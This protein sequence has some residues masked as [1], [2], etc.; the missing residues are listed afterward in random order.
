MSFPI[1]QPPTIP[2]IGNV[3]LIEPEAPNRSFD[4]LAKKYGEIYQLDLLGEKLI[5]VSSYKL[6]NELSDDTRFEKRITNALME[7]RN[8]VGDALFT[9]HPD[10]PNWGIAH[11]LLMPAFGTMKIKGM[12][13]EMRDISNQ[14]ILKW[15]RFGPDAVIDPS[16]DFTR[17]ALDTIA[18]C[19]MS[20]RLNS[21]Y[22]EGQPEFAV[23][24]GDFLTESGR[25]STRPRVVQAV[26]RG[27]TAK[28]QADIKFMRDLADEIVSA[29]R[30]NPIEKHDLLDTMLNSRDPKTGQGMSEESIAQN[31][32][33]FL[34]AGHET[35]SGMM[36]FMIYYLLKNPETLRK[37]RAQVDEV[38][39]TRPIQYDDFAK[40]P[41]LIAVMRE[42]LR[43]YPTAPG[44]VA[45]PLQDTTLDGGKFAVKKG[46][47]ILILVGPMQRDPSVWGKDAEQFRPER[48]LDF[49]ALPPNAWQPF[50]FG[51]RGCIGRAFAWQEV[52]LVMASIV[53]RFDLRLDDPSYALKIKQTLA[54]K[55]ADL[56]IRA[57]VRSTALFT[58]T[59]HH[60]LL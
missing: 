49:E 38:L 36:T 11:R 43:L 41:Y 34:I 13:E 52:C 21:F 48:M 24:M 27:T 7:V 16:D 47:S 10:E 20:Y 12:L 6:A 23:A 8:L 44:R 35:S 26:M 46:D 39:G 51:A 56:R 53:Q 22:R 57:S 40:L 4:L 3:A 25:R 19:S 37:L 60:P 15:E 2:L 33:T 59:P 5:F 55:P 54:V 14:L 30:A 45:S 58:S 17:V 28:Y 42:T 9:A 29:R 1:P 50:G 32:L 31:L 18:Y